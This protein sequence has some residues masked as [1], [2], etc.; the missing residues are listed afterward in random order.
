MMDVK[1]YSAALLALAALGGV[2][3]GVVLVVCAMREAVKGII[4]SFLG[5]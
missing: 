4:A 3:F 2:V 1:V 5:W